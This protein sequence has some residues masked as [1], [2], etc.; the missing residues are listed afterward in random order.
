MVPT[1]R[2]CSLISRAI[3]ALTLSLSVTTASAQSTVS[4]SLPEARA[5]ASNLLQ[6]GET[7][8]ALQVADGL[9][10]ANDEDYS[11]W[12]IRGAALRVLER[13]DL[14]RKAA[15]KAYRLAQT[16]GQKHQAARLA[17]AANSDE[18]RY[19]WAQLWLRLAQENSP[20]AQAS[21][22]IAQ[23]Y[24]QLRRLNPWSFS[25]SVGLAPSG[26]INGGSESET[27]YL[28]DN[29]DPSFAGF[30]AFFGIYDPET[31]LR[32]LG[33]NERA[34]SGTEAS[35]SFGA[36]YRLNES[37]SSATF[38][39]VNASLFRYRL[40]DEARELSPTSENGDFDRDSLSFGLRH[41]RVLGEGMRPATF[42]FGIGKNWYGGDPSNRYVT[43]SFSQPFLM[44]RTELLTLGV[45]ASASAS[46]SDDIPVRSL[47]ASARLLTL[48]PNGD[49]L[50]SSVRVTK[51]TSDIEDSD[52][53]SLSVGVNYAFA[54]PI[55]GMG[56]TLNADATYSDIGDTRFAPFDRTDTSVTFSADIAVPQAE[57]FGFQPVVSVGYE[58]TE[59]NLDQFDSSAGTFGLNFRSA[60]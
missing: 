18:K 6:Q 28:D 41:V 46:Y 22:Q 52:Y 12:V 40:S 42:N 34:L 59:S 49:R 48:R 14:A 55:F 3:F 30:L 25:A 4:L 33:D 57:F 38:A 24:Q 31:G 20:N 8:A 13:P 60:F 1:V 50:G 26:N 51:S 54:R 7:T 27:G 10:A 16:T 11:A 43:A 2:M 44:S 17:A 29:V 36:Q 47:G 37:A 32:L 23:D 21:R 19:S 58:Q 5:L 39:S 15:S 35:L 56:V 53:T 45:N 9:I